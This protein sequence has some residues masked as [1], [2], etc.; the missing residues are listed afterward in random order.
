MT[1]ETRPAV[2]SV[3]D[4]AEPPAYG[5]ICSLMLARICSNSPV[6]WVNLPTPVTAYEM[7]PGSFFARAISSGRLLMPSLGL[8]PIDC[9][10]STVIPMAVKLRRSRSRNR[11]TGTRPVLDHDLLSPLLAHAFGDD[12]KVGVYGAA[13]RRIQNEPYRLVRIV[14]RLSPRATGGHDRQ[15]EQA[16]QAS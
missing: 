8:I 13:R 11:P 12:P 14:P 6:K 4:C 16:L 3:S 7:L 5:T 10:C 1:S 9:G 15:Q 2:T